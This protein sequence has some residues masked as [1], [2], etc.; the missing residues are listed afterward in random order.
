MM[1][2]NLKK[3]YKTAMDIKAQYSG[4]DIEDTVGEMAFG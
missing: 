4:P 3:H 2:E 1:I